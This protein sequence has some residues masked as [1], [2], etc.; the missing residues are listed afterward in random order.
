MDGEIR[1]IPKKER[2]DDKE[3]ETKKERHILLNIWVIACIIASFIASSNKLSNKKSKTVSNCLLYIFN[4]ENYSQCIKNKSNDLEFQ[5]LTTKMQI[6]S[7]N[8]DGNSTVFITM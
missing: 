6:I 4:K 2:K 5:S 7:V 3:D 8:D 1:V